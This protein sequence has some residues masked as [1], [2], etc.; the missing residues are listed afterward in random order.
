[1]IALIINAH[2]LE[3]SRTQTRQ[4]PDGLALKKDQLIVQDLPV[5]RG[6]AHGA[7]ERPCQSHDRHTDKSLLHDVKEPSAMLFARRIRF[8]RVID[9]A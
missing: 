7:A 3:L 2:P 1:L 6:Q 9:G 5:G 4:R 8:G